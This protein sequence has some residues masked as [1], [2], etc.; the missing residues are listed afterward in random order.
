MPRIICQFSGWF[1]VNPEKTLVR[2]LGVDNVDFDVPAITLAEE[3]KTNPTLKDVVL[4]QFEDASKTAFDG[5][6]EELYLEIEKDEEEF[7]PDHNH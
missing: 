4:E 6:F 5:G 1:E 2:R 3:L 7:R